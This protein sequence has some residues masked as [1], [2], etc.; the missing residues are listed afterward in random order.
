[1]CISVFAI[2]AQAGLIFS[3][4]DFSSTAGLTT[5][6]STTTAITSDGT[7]LRITPASG[8]QSGAAYQTTPVTLGAG[9]TF[10]TTFDFRFTSPSFNPADGITFV[11]AAATTGLGGAGSGL[12]YAGVPNSVAIEFDTYLNGGADSSSN[13]VSIDT[14]GSVSDSN[15][16]NLYGI[17]NCSG[18]NESQSGCM[19]NGDLWRVLIGFDGTNL[20]ASAW[21]MTGAHAQ[22]TPFTV[23]TNLPLNVASYLG[24]TSAFVGV[25]GSTG[26]QY[27]NQDIVSWQFADTTQLAT[28]APEPATWIFMFGGFAGFALARRVGKRS[29]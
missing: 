3:Y 8:G 6:G 5:V 26:G 11:L 18:G 2:S 15:L 17:G 16:V 13:H 24:T 1:M 14:G 25:T 28:S 10:S 22:A 9:G 29:S 12:G 20:S 7:V 4:A 23:Y 27:E 21:D 19:A